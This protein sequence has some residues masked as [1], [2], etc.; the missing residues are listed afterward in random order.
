[1]GVY[2]Y[3]NKDAKRGAAGAV[4]EM[5]WAHGRRPLDSAARLWYTG[6]GDPKRMASKGRGPSPRPFSYLQGV[7]LRGSSRP[8]DESGSD[9]LCD[10]HYL[11]VFV[12]H[13]QSDP[14]THESE[15]YEQSLRD[16]G[17]PDIPASFG[18]P[19]HGPRGHAAGG[20]QAPALVLPCPLPQPTRA[21]HL[22]CAQ[23]PRRRALR[24][25]REVL[26]LMVPVQEGYPKGNA[27]EEGLSHCAHAMGL[28]VGESQKPL[29]RPARFSQRKGYGND[30]QQV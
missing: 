21:P 17:L 26:R 7:S 6:I 14:I 28:R 18:S 11:L 20:P 3:I 12:L 2:T 13:E 10:E 19:A 27:R 16:K 23:V 25:R 4:P 15:R 29:G 5:F 24:H 30:R 8:V 1:M 22:H 9:N